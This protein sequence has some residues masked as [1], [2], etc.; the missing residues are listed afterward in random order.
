MRGQWGL[1]PPVFRLLKQ[2]NRTLARPLPIQGNI[3]L[4]QIYFHAPNGIRTDDPC[5]R[6]VE[7]CA[8]AVIVISL[9]RSQIMK[10][11]FWWWGARGSVV[12]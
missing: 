3:E 12:S 4:T 11:S 1:R 10:V 2:E 7:N 6:G 8:R 9:T 5:V